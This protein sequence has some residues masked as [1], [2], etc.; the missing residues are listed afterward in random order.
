MNLEIM[1]IQTVQLKNQIKAPTMVI[2]TVTLEMTNFEETEI[3]L[4]QEDTMTEIEII[5]ITETIETIEII[6]T[7]ETDII[8]KDNIDTDLEIIKVI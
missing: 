8:I 2:I 1:M 7:I 5:E 3:I 6:E 4:N